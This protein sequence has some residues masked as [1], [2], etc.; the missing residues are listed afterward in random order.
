M[1]NTKYFCD[2]GCGGS[3]TEQQFLE[4]KN[5]C[6]T[7]GCPDFS[8]PLLKK[9]QCLRCGKWLQEGDHCDCAAHSES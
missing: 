6:A 7:K 8:K 2:G 1:A 9:T 4:G 3:V 5:K